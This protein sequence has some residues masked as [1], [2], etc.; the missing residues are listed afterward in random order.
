MKTYANKSVTMHEESG[1]YAD[2]YMSW[3]GAGGAD[4]GHDDPS[5]QLVHSDK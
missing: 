5:H 4:T 1:R 3:H 2:N